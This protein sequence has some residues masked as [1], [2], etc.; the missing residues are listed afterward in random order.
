MV[1]D[2]DLTIQILAHP[3]I[4]E[5][6]GLALSSRNHYLSPADRKLAPLLYA[7]MQAT[8]NQINSGAP[9]EAALETARNRLA[10]AGFG[11]ID[12][13]DLRRADDLQSCR[14]AV[15]HSRIFAAVWLGSTRLI[16]NLAL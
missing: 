2:L 11:N 13:F 15:P 12:Y 10:K 3:T 14:P 9:I 8:T 5:A 1:R 6:D 7:E 16:D 4:R